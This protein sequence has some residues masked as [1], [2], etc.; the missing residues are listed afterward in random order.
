VRLIE[1]AVSGSNLNVDGFAAEAGACCIPLYQQGECHGV[2]YVVSPQEKA[3]LRHK[4]LAFMRTLL[5][6]IAV[7]LAQ[8]NAPQAVP[9]A[10]P[11]M[12]DQGSGLL[13]KSAT[14][15]SV[16]SE[17]KLVAPTDATVLITGESG[18][19]K[20]LISQEIHR[21]SDRRDRPF[22]IVDCGAIVGSL[23]ESELF[24]HTRGAFTGAEKTSKGKLKE[25]E[26]GTIL[27]D[28]IGEL[29]I[30]IQAKLL[31]VVQEKQFS[32]VGS[33][34]YQSVDTRIIA[35]TN[36]DLAAR[37]RAGTFREDLFYRLNVFTVHAPP[38]RD[39]REDILV[40]ARHFLISCSRQ[41]N[42]SI[43][44]FTLEAEIAL[45]SYH[46]PGN[47]RELRNRLIRAVILCQNSRIDPSQLELPM[48]QSRAANGADA[49]TIAASEGSY[50]PRLETQYEVEEKLRGAMAKE[51]KYCLTTGIS[52]PLGQW[53]QEDL[54]QCSLE[55]HK[56]INLQAAQALGMPESTLRRKVVQT[57]SQ[58]QAQRNPG[59]QAV[60]SLLPDWINSAK[61]LHRD[62]RQ[63]LHE[64]LIEQLNT[65]CQL[66]ADAASLAGVSPPTYRRQ[67]RQLQ[68]IGLNLN[69]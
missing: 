43:E 30:D 26:G 21:L 27:L 36:V 67:L 12:R 2:L 4:D 10:E 54:I 11:T 51:I 33:N 14:M 42:K 24:G 28:E 32:A 58:G 22:V 60:A 29:A 9:L 69:D 53:L 49:A 61:D 44:G 47:V 45:Q 8:K 48:S 15:A 37:I 17:V 55:L 57:A 64:I 31:R 1:G 5:E 19:G 56:Y 59:W 18:T 68:P 65:H 7:P 62:A 39:R 41:Y 40:L 16:M 3:N 38:L 35:A 13:Y 23:I 20:E 66:Q 52:P 46:W 6:Y 34:Q 63:H 25:A 50:R